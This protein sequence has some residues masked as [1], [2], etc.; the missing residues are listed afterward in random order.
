MAGRGKCRQWRRRAR[1]VTLET[2][3]RAMCALVSVHQSDQRRIELLELRVQL[4]DEVVERLMAESRGIRCDRRAAAVTRL[5]LIDGRLSS[6]TG[7]GHGVRLTQRRATVAV[8]SASPDAGGACG[9]SSGRPDR[10]S[11]CTT[12]SLGAAGSPQALAGSSGPGGRAGD[13]PRTE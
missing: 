8:V 9:A 5:G 4:L 6:S 7:A 13:R 10:R 1:G 3:L 12:A 2:Y 11:P